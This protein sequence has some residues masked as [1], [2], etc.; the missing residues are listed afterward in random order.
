MSSPRRLV[1]PDSAE[2]VNT[3]GVG[4]PSKVAMRYRL[5]RAEKA[6]ILPKRIYLS[7]QRFAYDADELEAALANLPRDYTA[8]MTT[9]AAERR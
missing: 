7:P 4:S 2:I 9:G 3:I 5:K 6:G 8:A 1:L